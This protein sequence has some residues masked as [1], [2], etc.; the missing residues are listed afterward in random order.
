MA[1]ASSTGNARLR[2]RT[3]WSVVLA[4]GEGERMRPFVERWLGCHRPKQYCTFVG[5]RSMFQHTLDRADLVSHPAHKVTVIGRDHQEHVGRQLIGRAGVVVGQ[6]VNRDTAAGVFLPLTH[7]RAR[8][9]NATVLIFPSDHFVYPEDRFADA[10]RAAEVAAD[11]W[12]DRLILLGIA[13]DHVETDYGWIEVGRQ[14]GR[15]AGWEVH[16]VKGFVEKPGPNYVRTRQVSRALWN[17]MVVAAKL[18]ALWEHGW[19]HIPDVMMHFET[20]FRGIGSRRELEILESAYRV[21]PARNFSRHLLSC[22]TDRLAV[23]EVTGVLWSDW[24]R[25]QRVLESL[26]RIGK[27]A[28]FAGAAIHLEAI[29]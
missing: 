29:H 28:A 26:R 8:E 5:T 1:P 4:G 27:R 7:V 24:G 20:L 22:A 17:T 12:P 25:E 2:S 15:C 6:P 18:P 16:A 11:R 9:P 10:V 19:R 14:I 3:T 21:M 13:P 23:I